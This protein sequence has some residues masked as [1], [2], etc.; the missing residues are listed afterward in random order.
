MIAFIHN[1]LLFNL[2]VVFDALGWAVLHSLWQGA[3]AGLFI[4]VARA[5]TRDGASD[6]RY[7]LGITTLCALFAAF[8]ATFF[9]YFHAGASVHAQNINALDVINITLAQT[10]SDSAQ[11]PLGRLGNYANVLGTIWTIG[12]ALFGARYLAAFR[13]THK[14]RTTGLSALPADWPTRFNALMVQSGMGANLKSRVKAYVSDHVSS[15]VTFGFFKPV[16][17]VPTWFFTG[18]SADQCEVIILHELAHIR[19]HDY[20]TNILQIFIKTVFFYHPAVQFIC[21]STDADREHACDDF[22]I[23]IT[24]KPENLATALG[25]IRLQAAQSSGAFVLSADGRDGRDAPFM[26]R[27]RRLMGTPINT[28]RINTVRGITATL[29]LVTTTILAMLV[30]ATQSIA[31]PADK[32]TIEAKKDKPKK[33]FSIVVNGETYTR[34]TGT[35]NLSVDLHGVT[36]ENGRSYHIFNGKKYSSKYS[37]EFFSKD[38]EDYVVKTKNGKRYIEIDGNWFKVNHDRNTETNRSH[39]KTGASIDTFV[40]L[41]SNGD[42]NAFST[43]AKPVAP[44]PQAMAKAP[45]TP[46]TPTSNFEING[47]V[48]KKVNGKWQALSLEEKK[49]LGNQT[50]TQTLINFENS[51]TLMTM[52]GITYKIGSNKNSRSRSNSHSKSSRKHSNAN[53]NSS[54]AGAPQSPSTPRVYGSYVAP[55]IS[56][57]PTTRVTMNE[58]IKQET[59]AAV[60][61]AL[62]AALSDEEF[63]QIE[64]EAEALAEQYEEQREEQAERLED[65]TETLTELRAER[66]EQQREFIEEQAE[67]QRELAQEQKELAHELAHDQEKLARKMAKL[68]RHFAKEQKKWARAQAEWNESTARQ[69]SILTREIADMRSEFERGSKHNDVSK[70]TDISVLKSKIYRKQNE[71]KKLRKNDQFSH[72][73]VARLQGELGQLQGQVSRLY[74]QRGQNMGELGRLQGKLGKLQ[75]E[76]GNMQG[77]SGSQQARQKQT[78]YTELGEKLIP[79]LVADGYMK[80]PQ[81]PVKIDLTKEDI[82]INGRQLEHKQEDKYCSIISE[83]IER[84]QDTKHIVVKQNYMKVDFKSEDGHHT[85]SYTYSEDQ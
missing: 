41:A 38:G 25:T 54:L 23:H 2:P 16:V 47:P 74:G 43:P 39:A 4:W 37:Y 22:A 53:S 70:N 83:Y 84:G 1:T 6:L 80:T 65:K 7:V 85:S 66:V 29:M 11:Y 19:R 63:E 61:L 33:P 55:Q 44:R 36:D 79:A 10:V 17:L 67:L 64:D 81:T 35:N 82:F 60:E 18:L 21:R 76:L 46:D 45:H 49:T 13:L 20:A 56:V 40:S 15:P 71:I 48:Y 42:S 9:Y 57:S 52:D 75:G 59:D 31:D 28:L 32:Q 34:G 14:L 68:D 50:T 77:N 8:V 73:R 58:L 24:D 5:V 27:L 51:N 69:Q 3:L 72:T 30:S 78:R 26:L 62:A 12:F